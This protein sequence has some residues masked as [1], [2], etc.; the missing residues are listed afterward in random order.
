MRCFAVARAVKGN[1][2]K[3]AFNGTS[4]IYCAYARLAGLKLAKLP[5]K[6]SPV[7]KGATKK[8]KQTVTDRQAM[9]DFGCFLLQFIYFK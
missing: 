6:T 8:V 9:E 3:R 7:S 4:A 5:A 2:G 1:L